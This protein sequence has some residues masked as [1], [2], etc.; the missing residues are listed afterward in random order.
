MCRQ[1]VESNLLREQICRLHYRITFAHYADDYEMA[2]ANSQLFLQWIEH[3][4]L[5][6]TRSTPRHTSGRRSTS[7]VMDR[8]LHIRFPEIYKNATAESGNGAH[9][10]GD[11][12]AATKQAK[13][14]KWAV[15]TV[16]DWLRLGKPWSPFI[17]EFGYDILRLMPSAFSDEE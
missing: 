10:S 7:L 15:H 2:Q 6:S 14:R 16:Q 13:A 8:V 5:K 9:L 11:P 17:R 1:E 4:A 3:A 12:A